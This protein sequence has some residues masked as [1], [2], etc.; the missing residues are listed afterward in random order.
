MIDFGL[1]LTYALIGVAVVA[2]V[3]F[4]VVN[5]VKKPATAKS[6]LIGIGGL[7]VLLVLSYLFSSGQDAELYNTTEGTAKWV[8]T[9]LVVL[10]ILGA[11]AILSIL[12]SEVTRIFK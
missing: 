6:A 5:M 9:G 7:I 3:I 4:A 2:I 8:G 10:Y 11:L 12:F 1:Y